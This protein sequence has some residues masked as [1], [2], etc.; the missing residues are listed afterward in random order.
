MERGQVSKGRH[1]LLFFVVVVA[2]I[3]YSDQK[4]LKDGFYFI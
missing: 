1:V 3:K 2:V 4:C